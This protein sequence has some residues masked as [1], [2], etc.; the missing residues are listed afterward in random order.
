MT[1]H[2]P[3]WARDFRDPVI[4]FGTN[5]KV[6]WGP[7]SNWADTTDLFV[8][9]PAPGRSGFYETEKGAQPFTFRTETFRI[10]HGEQFSEETRIVRSSRPGVIINDFIDRLPPDFPLLALARSQ[11]IGSSFASMLGLYRAASVQEARTALEGVSAFVGNWVLADAHGHIGYAA[12]S[13][14]PCAVMRW[15]PFPCPGGPGPTNGTAWFLRTA[16]RALST[17]PRGILPRRTTRSSSRNRPA[18]R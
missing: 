3:S 8:E 2:S 9:K 6:A 1:P 12:P 14:F 10:R 18:T 4:P 15:A 17:L 7:T 13:P 16:A 11:S 5:G